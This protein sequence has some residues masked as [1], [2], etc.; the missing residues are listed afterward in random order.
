[1]SKLLI[2][3]IYIVT[4]L[5]GLLHCANM[6]G[7]EGFPAH[8]AIDLKAVSKQS[9]ETPVLLTLTVTNTG[10]D[11]ISYSVALGA[12]RYPDAGWF[13]GEIKDSQGRVQELRMSNDSAGGTSGAI[14]QIAPGQSV[15][16]PAVIA[17]LPQGTYCIQVGKGNSVQI[18]VKDDEGLAQ[19][20]HQ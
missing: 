5:V 12:G 20:W 4:I 10:K 1:M 6:A 11:P 16:A 18:E 15:E 9:A 17:P 7:D 3:R 19:K 8:C 2:S 13:K 14:R